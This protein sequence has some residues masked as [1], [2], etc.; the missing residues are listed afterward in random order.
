MRCV[1]YEADKG[2]GEINGKE[3]YD[4]RTSRKL[5][6]RWHWISEPSLPT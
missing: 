1:A 2:R 5:R 6:Y 4:W 3:G